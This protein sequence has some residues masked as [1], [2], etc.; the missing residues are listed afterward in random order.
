MPVETRSDRASSVYLHKPGCL[1]HFSA[2]SH[3]PFLSSISSVP[4]GTWSRYPLWFSEYVSRGFGFLDCA[5]GGVPYRWTLTF[6]GCSIARL[7][8][9]PQSPRAILATANLDNYTL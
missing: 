7:S 4:K 8:L 9:A 2:N 5:Y 3:R 1:L 6:A